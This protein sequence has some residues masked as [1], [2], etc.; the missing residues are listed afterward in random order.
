MF[1]LIIHYRH[2]DHQQ[3][4]VDSYD[5]ALTVVGAALSIATLIII[6]PTTGELLRRAI[7]AGQNS[8]DT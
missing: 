6:Q 7:T 5:E 3:M 8:V 1:T 2:R 4:T